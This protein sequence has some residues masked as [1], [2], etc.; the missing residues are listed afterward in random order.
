[1]RQASFA[2]A[3]HTK[4]SRFRWFE[5]PFRNL[6]PKRDAIRQGTLLRMVTLVAPAELRKQKWPS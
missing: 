2:A 6:P 3:L 1:L 5:A 4:A